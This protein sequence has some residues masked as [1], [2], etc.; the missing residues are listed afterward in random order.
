MTFPY[1]AALAVG[2]AACVTDLRERRIPNVLTLGSALAAFLYHALN[3]GPNDLLL[4]LAGWAA[5]IAIFFAP[6]A[7]GGLGGGDVKLMGSIGAWL[8]PTGALWVAIYTGI[9]GGVLALAVAMYLGYLRTS[10]RNIWLLLAHWR[11]AGI[12]PLGDVTLA[13]SKGP[14]LAYAVPIFVGIVVTTWLHS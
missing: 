12:T 4:A 2:L 11:V 9:A 13:S 14:R 3:G 10:L 6:F 5:G 8:G 1:V 7:L